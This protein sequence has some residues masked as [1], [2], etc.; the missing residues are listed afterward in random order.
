MTTEAGPEETPPR[1]STSLGRA[2][3]RI[4]GSG[5]RHVLMTANSVDG[6]WPYALT[7]AG[8]LSRRG[9]RTSLAVFSGGL[10][11]SLRAEAWAVPGLQIFEGRDARKA[12]EWLLSLARVLR[13]EVVHLNDAVHGALGWPVPAIVV[14]HH[15][16]CAWGQAPDGHGAEMRRGLVGAARVVATSKAM[17]EVLERHHGPLPT[18]RV[19][20]NARPPSPVRGLEKEPWVLASGSPGDEAANVQVLQ[21]AAR[22]MRIRVAGEAEH[23]PGAEPGRSGLQL[24]GRLG[25]E[26]M[27]VAMARAAVY[28]QPALVD[29]F[30]LA[31]LD[32]ALQGCALVLS[33][34]RS[35]REM[36]DG[37]AAFVPPHDG[38]AWAAELRNLLEDGPRRR[39]LAE[40]AR[41]RAGDFRPERQAEEMLRIYEGARS[42]ARRESA[43]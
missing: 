27:R 41:T 35:L 2:W 7:L 39:R 25:P 23:P 43:R 17:L 18:A 42:E 16:P 30:G 15:C 36:W 13:P 8:A 19:V 33:D 38:E 5:I 26:S 14:A 40:A 34:L 11:P 9:V 4:S 28:A 3:A 12:G 1:A 10:P 31:A 6:V 37:A 29:P 32:A 22:T 20:H 21:A 24:V